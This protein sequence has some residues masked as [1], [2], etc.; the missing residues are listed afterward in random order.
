MKYLAS[1]LLITSHATFASVASQR[2]VDSYLDLAL[3]N[4]SK[5]LQGKKSK[6]SADLQ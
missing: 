3:K 2:T 4:D 1:I 6:L 5:T